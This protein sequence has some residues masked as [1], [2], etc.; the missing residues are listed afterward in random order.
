MKISR[1]FCFY[2]C[3]CTPLLSGGE[4]LLDM[5]RGGVFEQNSVVFVEKIEARFGG[6]VVE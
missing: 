1:F 6:E 5:G 3:R 4:E 2:R